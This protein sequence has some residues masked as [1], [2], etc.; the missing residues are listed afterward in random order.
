VVSN[1]SE[2][3]KTGPHACTYGCNMIGPTANRYTVWAAAAT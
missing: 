3:L 2:I 1:H